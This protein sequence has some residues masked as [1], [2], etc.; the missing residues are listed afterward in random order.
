MADYSVYVALVAQ[1]LSDELSTLVDFFV[2]GFNRT[3]AD[4]Y[5]KGPHKCCV[6]VRNLDLLSQGLP[7]CAYHNISDHDQLIEFDIIQIADDDT[8]IAG[9]ANRIQQIMKKPISK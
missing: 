9:I 8:Y 5:L 7:G 2:P 3:K 4:K 1:A 6:G